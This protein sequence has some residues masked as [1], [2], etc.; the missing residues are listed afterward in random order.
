MRPAPSSATP[1]QATVT[2]SSITV[3]VSSP[4]TPTTAPTANQSRVM[5]GT[6]ISGMSGSHGPSTKTMKSA[7]GVTRSAPAAAPCSRAPSRSRRPLQTAHAAYARPK[8][9]SSAAAS[10]PRADSSHSSASVAMPRPTPTAPM[11]TEDATCPAPHSAVTSS[12][13]PSAQSRA[14]PS[15]TNGSEWSIP[16]RVWTTASEAVV[17]SRSVVV[18]VGSGIGMMVGRRSVRPDA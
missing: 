2:A 14:R 8:P 12:V 13:R 11:T 4:N 16:S 7:H 6:T 17:P 3:I 10:S 18:W 15:A 9:I 5:P 1:R